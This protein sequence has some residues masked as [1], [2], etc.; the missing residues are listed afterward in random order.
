VSGKG[1]DASGKGA[2]GAFGLLGSFAARLNGSGSPAHAVS[3]L[4]ASAMASQ[5]VM[6]VRGSIWQV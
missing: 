3:S 5:A 2:S 4:E 6:R 1:V